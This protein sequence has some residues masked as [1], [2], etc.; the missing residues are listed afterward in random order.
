[1][2]IKQ[3]LLINTVV[4]VASMLFMLGLLSF[5]VSSLESNIRIARD[6]GQVES[7]ILQLRRNEKDFIARKDLKY[8]DKFNK[9]YTE[10]QQTISR[11][12]DEFQLW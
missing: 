7:M 1:M 6:I 11:L 10:L 12:D 3:K 9:Q 4:A 2:L 8:F 5:A